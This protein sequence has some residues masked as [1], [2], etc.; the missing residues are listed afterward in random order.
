MHCCFHQEQCG[1]DKYRHLH[2]VAKPD[3][4]I[5]LMRLYRPFCAQTPCSIREWACAQIPV[6]TGSQICAHVREWPVLLVHSHTRAVT[7]GFP[8]HCY[9]LRSAPPARRCPLCARFFPLLYWLLF[10]ARLRYHCTNLM[11]SL[12]RSTAAF[13]DPPSAIRQSSVPPLIGHLI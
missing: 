7:L 10:L 6:T 4:R 12:C 9:T 3:T 1:Q 13:L 11:R 8:T 2:L 5:S